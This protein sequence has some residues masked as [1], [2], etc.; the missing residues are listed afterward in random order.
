[1]VGRRDLKGGLRRSRLQVNYP[2]A[3]IDGWG[4]PAP[5]LLAGE[6]GEK[7]NVVKEGILSLEKE[8]QP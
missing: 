8:K 2:N 4:G 5:S 1:L 7:K 3:I 6:E